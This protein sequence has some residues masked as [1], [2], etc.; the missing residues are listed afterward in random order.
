VIPRIV[1]KNDGSLRG[2]EISQPGA[3]SLNL[4]RVLPKIQ[5]E[6]CTPGET[7]RRVSDYESGGWARAI[8][9]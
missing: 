8:G 9:Y 2:K 5:R 1:G 6:V 4:S 3:E 7:S